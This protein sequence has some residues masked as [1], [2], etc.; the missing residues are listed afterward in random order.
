MS[1]RVLSREIA[2]GG[3]LA[4]SASCLRHGA[5]RWGMAVAV[6][7]GIVWGLGGHGFV[8]TTG[9]CVGRLLR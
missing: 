1:E 4:A 5:M 8:R 7:F 2:V 6:G 9:I 3:G